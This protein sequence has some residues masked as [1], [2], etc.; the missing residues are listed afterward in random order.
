MVKVTPPETNPATSHLKI[1]RPKAPKRSERIISLWHPFSGAKLL[2]VLGSVMKPSK[3]NQ[4]T[5]HPYGNQGRLGESPPPL[6]RI[7]LVVKV[8][9]PSKPIPNLPLGAK[10]VEP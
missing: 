8:N 7:L 9:Q 2:F 1:G 4:A 6:D 3:S 10:K 5:Y